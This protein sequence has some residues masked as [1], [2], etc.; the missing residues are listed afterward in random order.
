M[1]AAKERNELQVIQSEKKVYWMQLKRAMSI[2][3][4][5]SEKNSALSEKTIT[6]FTLILPWRGFPL[7][8]SLL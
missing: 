3:K 6:N 2:K 8:R 4:S 7:I 5:K 1:K